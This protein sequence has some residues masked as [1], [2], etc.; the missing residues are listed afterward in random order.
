MFAM[1][2]ASR[3]KNSKKYYPVQR[4]MA[5]SP[6]ANNEQHFVIAADMELSK[7]N[8][9]LY[10]QSRVYQLKLDITP[11]FDPAQTVEVF[12]IRPTWMNMKA[13]QF[14]YKQFVKNSEEERSPGND[15]RW[16]DFRVK[17]GTG[18]ASLSPRVLEEMNTTEDSV[19][20]GEYIFTEVHGPSNGQNHFTW[21]GS[22]GSGEYNIVQEYDLTANTD[23]EPSTAI[24]TA[25]YD[26]LDDDISDGQ[27][28]HLQ[29][30]GNLPPYA[31]TSLDRDVFTKVATLQAAG[32]TA[33]RL[34]SGFFDA[35]CGFVLVRTSAPVPI[36]SDTKTQFILTAKSGDYKGVHA[37]SMLE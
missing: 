8:H 20:S 34:S 26:G 4:M 15:A 36:T 19:P 31:A 21:V 23:A 3:S 13:Y 35:P 1:A 33:Q 22:T 37:P 25:P 30:H 16:N 27:K 6:S 11:D 32:A 9:R 2:R 17:L 24:G 28:D 29:N 5:L 10:R 14:A 12:T 7:T 18:T